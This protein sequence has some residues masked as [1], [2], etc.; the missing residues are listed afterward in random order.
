MHWLKS[1][2]EVRSQKPGLAP[3]NN[4]NN[5]IVINHDYVHWLK[6]KDEV[7]SKKPGLA[8][9]DAKPALGVKKNKVHSKNYYVLTLTSPK[10][11]FLMG[12]LKCV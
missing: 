5:N 7:R 12:A 6:S 2:D 1:K 8:A 10:F 11:Y 9:C 4:N 3:H